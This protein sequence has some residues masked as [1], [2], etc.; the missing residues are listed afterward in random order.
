MPHRKAWKSNVTLGS[1]L[2]VSRDSTVTPGTKRL[3]RNRT[4][5]HACLALLLGSMLSASRG[6]AQN[7]DF[8]GGP[9]LANPAIHNVYMDF[10]WDSDN[11]ATINQA[12]IDGFTSSLVNSV[13]FNSASQYGVG[14]ASFTGSNQAGILCPPPIIFG[15]TDFIA[16]SL[17]MECMTAPSPIPPEASAGKGSIASTTAGS[18]SQIEVVPRT[19][20]PAS[21][22]CAMTA[23]T[24]AQAAASA[25]ASEPTWIRSLTA[26]SCAC[27]T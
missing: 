4:V 9:V 11:P 22:P 7:L 21:K 15:I 16:I 17:W 2:A 23:S 27:S 19:W 26:Y 25:S 3:K 6:T 1:H 13:Y 12:S 20:P 10:F 24:P 5:L 18:S 8:N 14:A